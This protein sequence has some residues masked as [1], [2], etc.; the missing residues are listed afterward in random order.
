MK[1]K[2]EEMTDNGINLN[3]KINW[4]FIDYDEL[5]KASIKRSSHLIKL[6]TSIK[7]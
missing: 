2:Q 3:V 1:K 5:I 4:R 7:L 6:F